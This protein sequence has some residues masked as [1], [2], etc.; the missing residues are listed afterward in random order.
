MT[1]KKTLETYREIRPVK[2]ILLLIVAIAAPI[3]LV[4]MTGAHALKSSAPLQAGAT[5][6]CEATKMRLTMFGRSLMTYDSQT[7]NCTVAVA[8]PRKAIE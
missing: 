1:F 8:K 6:D 4:R 5:A 2:R 3:V 7:G